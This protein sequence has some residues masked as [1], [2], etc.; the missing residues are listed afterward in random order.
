MKKVS[1]KYILQ[2]VANYDLSGPNCLPSEILLWCW[3]PE[4]LC[5]LRCSCSENGTFRRASILLAEGRPSPKWQLTRV[6]EGRCYRTHGDTR[7]KLWVSYLRLA[8]CLQS[9]FSVCP[10]SFSF[11]CLRCLDFLRMACD[12]NLLLELPAE[13]LSYA[14]T[15]LLLRPSDAFSNIFIENHFFSILSRW[16]SDVPTCHEMGSSSCDPPFAQGSAENDLHS[17]D[18][19]PVAAPTDGN[20]LWCL[21]EWSQSVFIESNQSILCLLLH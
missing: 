9:G 12:D 14:E 15:R 1:S 6:A 18:R 8:K 2:W 10:A 19:K 17:L 5:E 20:C 11:L 21:L 16:C 7:F 4:F 13:D 3:P